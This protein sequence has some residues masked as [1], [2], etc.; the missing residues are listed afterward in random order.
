[1]RAGSAAGGQSWGRGRG[2]RGLGIGQ[3][4][5]EPGA[6]AAQS[7]RKTRSAKAAH[8]AANGSSTNAAIANET[9]SSAPGSAVVRSNHASMT[10]STLVA[11][12][13]RAQRLSPFSRNQPVMNSASASQLSRP[14]QAAHQ[15]AA[16]ALTGR[17][18]AKY[19]SHGI[20][21]R[22][23]ATY[24]RP[25]RRRVRAGVPGRRSSGT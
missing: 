17:E 22:P 13:V 4:P 1:V 14:T 7:E 5:A 23:M 9:A 21:A 19:P 16:V 24:A 11:S 12:A 25:S 15:C 10:S 8:S 3:R 20:M 2:L 18:T 6:A